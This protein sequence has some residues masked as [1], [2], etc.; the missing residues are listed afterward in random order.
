MKSVTSVPDALT[1]SVTFSEDLS[2]AR[3]PSAR[4]CQ[5]SDRSKIESLSR[6]EPMPEAYAAAGT[7]YSD[8]QHTGSSYE[9]M[10]MRSERRP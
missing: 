7:L 3:F 2:G 10:E 9:H 4:E 1:P 5:D 6:S 8:T